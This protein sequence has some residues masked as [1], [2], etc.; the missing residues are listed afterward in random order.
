MTLRDDRNENRAPYFPNIIVNSHRGIDRLPWERR[1]ESLLPALPRPTQVF[2][3]SAPG[4]QNEKM[5]IKAQ[6]PLAVTAFLVLIALGIP[7]LAFGQDQGVGFGFMLG[8]TNGGNAKIW[9]S[10]ASALDVGLGMSLGSETDAITLYGDFLLHKFDTFRYDSFAPDNGNLFSYVGIGSRVKF[11][12]D[13]RA[14]IRLLLGVDYSHPDSP[15]DVFVEVVPILD[16]LPRK[17]LSLSA[18][19]GGRL[20]IK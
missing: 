6:D 12:K 16:F 19:I 4:R 5:R 15:F 11:E 9:L 2:D 14:G 10:E 17:T 1:I 18:V 3:T 20:F 13:L 7:P 8:E